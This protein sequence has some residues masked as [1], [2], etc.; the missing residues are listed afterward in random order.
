MAPGGEFGRF[1]DIRHLHETDSTNADVL[2]LARAG[3]PEGVVVV[4]RFQRA[5]RGR[6]G[7]SWTAP[8]GS[9]LLA[10]VL[11][12]PRLAPDRAPLVALAAAVAA[13]EACEEVAGVDLGL[14]WPNDVVVEPGGA[15]GGVFGKLAGLLA[16]SLVEGDV[17]R[18]VVV[19]LG[20]NLTRTADP[21]ESPAFV[22]D[23]GRSATPIVH[24]SGRGSAG[25]AGAVYL[26]DLAGRPVERDDLLGSWL[27]HLDRW[28]STLSSPEGQPAVVEAYRRRCTTLGRLVRVDL[29]GGAVKGTAVDLTAGGHLVVATAGARHIVAAGDV[30]HL[31]AS[32]S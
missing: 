23:R 7:R 10:S 29:A 18:A 27:V 2:G 13:A 6:R 9:A 31:R 20:L 15:G 32:G 24:R 21:P 26:E 14:K 8:P 1:T 11:L 30:V 16:E 25:V 4:T 3:A 19:G 17:L 22:D 12:R 28:C 5:G